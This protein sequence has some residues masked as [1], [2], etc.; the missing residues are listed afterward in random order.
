M[1]KELGGIEAAESE[2]IWIG[3]SVTERPRISCSMTESV[4]TS[5]GENVMVS[6]V[7]IHRLTDRSKS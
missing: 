4:V 2:V 3:V 6:E 7:R 1:S 5:L